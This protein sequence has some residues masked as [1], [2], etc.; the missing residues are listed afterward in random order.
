MN[1]GVGLLRLSAA[2]WKDREAF[3]RYVDGTHLDRHENISLY[4]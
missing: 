4:Y 2:G 3:L 1:N